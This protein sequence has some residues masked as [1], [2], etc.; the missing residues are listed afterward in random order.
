M[1]GKDIMCLKATDESKIEELLLGSAYPNQKVY[2]EYNDFKGEIS[3]LNIWG[4]A[5]STDDLV[6]I[7]STCGNTTPIPDILNWSEISNS[8]IGGVVE[9]SDVDQLCHNSNTTIPIPKIMPIMQNQNDAIHLCKILQA[10]LAYPKTLEDYNKWK[11]N[12]YFLEFLGPRWGSHQAPARH[13]PGNAHYT[14]TS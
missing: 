10:Q 5:L 3:E 9:D 4:K 7:T 11:G 1:F 8:M 2:A 14:E 12:Q 13:S 6:K